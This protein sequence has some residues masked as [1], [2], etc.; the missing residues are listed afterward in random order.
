[1][2]E[3]IV[4]PSRRAPETDMSDLRAELRAATWT[5]HERLDDALPLTSARLTRDQF[6]RLMRRFYSIYE[7]LELR[8]E[9]T[10]AGAA[11]PTLRD[12]L[13][14]RQ[15][16]LWLEADLRQLG[17]TPAAVAALPRFEAGT[18]AATVPALLGAMYVTEGATLGGRLIAGHL[19]RHLGLCHGN[20]YTFFRSYGSA[21]GRMWRG[22][23]DVLRLYDSPSTRPAIITGAVATFRAFERWLV[24]P[25]FEPVDD[26]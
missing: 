26:R 25:A 16:R 14:R 10:A 15:K 1:M 4:S 11:D 6:H 13:A 18:L 19:E 21:V 7:P 24:A 20:G 5:A 2:A 8:L 3:V 22:F 17:D 23:L 12:L 9:A